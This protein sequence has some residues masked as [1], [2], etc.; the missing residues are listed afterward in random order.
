MIFEPPLH[1]KNNDIEVEF[2][3]FPEWI[4]RICI[5]DMYKWMDLN[6]MSPPNYLVQLL[7]RP[8]R[9]PSK[10]LLRKLEQFG[11]D[12]GDYKLSCLSLVVLVKAIALSMSFA[13]PEPI[14]Q[15]LDEALSK[16][17]E[18]YV[19]DCAKLLKL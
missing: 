14:I 19:G 12:K 11:I 5:K 10:T 18:Y 17:D 4:M 1:M 7:L 15:A 6:D 9:H 13:L 2:E 3:H 16:R 8:R